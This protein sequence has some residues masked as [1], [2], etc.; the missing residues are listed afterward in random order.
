MFNFIC[1][2][3]FPDSKD[4]IFEMEQ[5]YKDVKQSIFLFVSLLSVCGEDVF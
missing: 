5:V 3:N 4:H 1:I 2:G